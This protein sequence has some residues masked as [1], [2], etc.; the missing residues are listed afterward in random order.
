VNPGLVLGRVAGVRISV[1][2]SWLI[3]FALIAWTLAAVVFPEQNPGHSD[4][5]YATMAVVASA[6][7]FGSL[8]LHELGHAVQARRE[9][10]EIE[11]ITLW[12][13]GGV[14]AFRGE[15]P[16]ALAE[17]RIALAGPLVTAVL[18]S[19]F[20]LMTA[21]ALPDP[22][23]GVLAWLAVMNLLLLGFNLLPALPLDGGRV[24]HALVWG[25]TRDRRR[26]TSVGAG[27]GRA[28][29]F[30]M[31]AG[32]LAL[33]LGGA[34]GSGIWFAFLGWFLL[35][36]A[37]AEQRDLALR[38]ALGGLRVEDLMVHRPVVAPAGEPLNRFIDEVAHVHRFTTYPV[39]DDGKVVGLLPF[40]RVAA[41][42]RV[43]WDDSTVRDCMLSLAECAVV[44]PGAPLLDALAEMERQGRTRAL[45]LEEGELAGL[46]SITDVGRL[47]TEALA[48]RKDAHR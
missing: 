44:S 39:V 9:S 22:A 6:A 17:L 46:L 21:V 37:M 29:G 32:G 5:A 41:T 11:G 4:G 19:I 1:H 38:E 15:F 3:V 30:V 7:F 48:T 40:A 26:A 23:G 2:W 16:S 20:G 36:A 12:L 47:V 24:L 18:A 43:R 10:M 14:A 8:L 33:V 28:L 42:P 25:R 34:A 31:I 13:F 27:A 35:Q 45:V